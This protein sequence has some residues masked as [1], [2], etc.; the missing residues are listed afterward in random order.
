ML[1]ATLATLVIVWLDDPVKVLVA[2]A[3]KGTPAEFAVNL[4]VPAPKPFA[5]AVTLIPAVVLILFARRVAIEE[6]LSTG[7][8]LP[9]LPFWSKTVKLIVVPSIITP[10]KSPSTGDPPGLVIFILS[11]CAILKTPPVIAASGTV[12]APSVFPAQETW[13]TTKLPVLI[14][15]SGETIIVPDIDV[16]G[17]QLPFVVDTV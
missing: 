10:V 1:L 8:P 5:K 7:S 13:E 6:S 3:V 4:I 12:I 17:S 2:E 11:T 9:K 16:S 15:I 14:V